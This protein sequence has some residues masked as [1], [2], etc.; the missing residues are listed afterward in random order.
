MP[1]TYAHY[2]FG[3]EVFKSLPKELTKEINRYMPLYKIGLHGPDLLF[4]YK[5]LNKNAINQEGTLMHERAGTV[6]FEKARAI[7]SRSEQRQASL[8][9]VYGC[10]CHF[11]LDSMCHPYVDEKIAEGGIGHMEIEIEFDRF[12]LE[13]DGK[14]P[15]KEDLTK[16]ISVKDEYAAVIAPY[17]VGTTPKDIKSAL[18]SMKRYSHFL[19]MPNKFKRAFVCSVLK[20]AGEFE[21]RKE[22]LMSEEPHVNCQDSNQ[23]LIELY[24]EAIALA[25]RLISEYSATV[26]QDKNLDAQYQLNFEGQKEKEANYAV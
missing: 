10:I 6:F 8:A 23:R 17:F 26:D 9:Y 1:S 14:E 25:V 22:L 15:L 3:K 13:Q 19:M 4:Y 18:V 2:K 7:T 11:A 5:P 16:H 12:L 20:L 24:H 21:K